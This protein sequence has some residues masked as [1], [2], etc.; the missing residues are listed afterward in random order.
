MLLVLV[1]LLFILLLSLVLVA[2]VLGE[3]QQFTILLAIV[4]VAVAYTTEYVAGVVV[5]LVSLPPTTKKIFWY[6]KSMTD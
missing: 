6:L 5:I 3:W 4:H 1:L 2:V